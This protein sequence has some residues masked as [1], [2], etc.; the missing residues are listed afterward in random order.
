MKKKVSPVDIIVYT[1]FISIMIIS[2][3]DATTKCVG[4]KINL[5]IVI[6]AIITLLYL[7]FSSIKKY[8]YMVGILIF[9]LPRP[10][11]IVKKLISIVS[12]LPVF[13][14]S[15]I[16]NQGLIQEYSGYFLDA[17]VVLEVL[18]VL[19]FYF[20]IVIN[21]KTMLVIILGY[22]IITTYYFIGV[23]NLYKDSVWFLMSGL[24]LY[25][26]N[27][28]YARRKKLNNN[29]LEVSKRYS[30]K[31]ISSTIFITLIA[32]FIA[33]ILPHDK[34]PVTLDWIDGNVFSKFESFKSKE[35]LSSKSKFSIS[36]TGFQENPGRL[37]GAVKTDDSLVLVIKDLDTSRNVHLRGS[38]RDKYNG[39]IWEKSGIDN[40]KFEG[41]VASKGPDIAYNNKTIKITHKK[42]KVS[43]AFNVL[44]PDSIEN[45]WGYAYEDMDLE[46]VHPGVIKSGKS[47]NVKYRDYNITKDIIKRQYNKDYQFNYGIMGRYLSIPDTIPERVSELVYQ[48]T[49]DCK[50][51]YERVSAIENYLKENYPYSMQ[52]SNLPEGQDF[53][54]YFLFQEKKGYCTYFAS[55]MAVMTRMAGVPSRYVEGFLVTDKSDGSGEVE[56]LNSDAHAW[57][58]IYLGDLGWVTFDPT[59]GNE[60]NSIETGEGGEIDP[61]KPDN[62]ETPDNINYDHSKDNRKVIDKDD[63]FANTDE[64]NKNESITININWGQV[65]K[66]IGIS[67]AAIFI[68][69][70][71]VYAIRY[72]IIKTKNKF[73][74]YMISKM[75][76][77]GRL[78]GYPYEGG[79]TLRE[80][81]ERFGRNIKTDLNYLIE[82]FE[83]HMYNKKRISSKDYHSIKKQM[84]RLDS[85]VRKESGWFKFYYSDFK[86][87]YVFLIKYISIRKGHKKALF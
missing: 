45:K 37:G 31:L 77:Y 9:I 58:E 61:S 18:L 29:K 49:K 2:I 50:T 56:V 13:I 38:I 75:L 54:D 34:K 79:D 78:L 32:G 21:K 71:I 86:N 5:L 65:F 20:I 33:G 69:M 4:L 39:Y 27:N 80:Y 43:T 85:I 53:V 28:F 73:I 1:L 42:L 25:G 72:R 11:F 47:Y 87:M 70:M 63:D 74:Y 81:I 64:S 10:L 30:Y 62:T 76:L 40:R 22:S 35:K 14:D 66:C 23:E 19:V 83:L 55:A 51:P 7:F 52:T 12:E 6:V 16:Q 84:R 57:V 60:S 68:I 24:I 59:P 36:R 15:L 41:E 48:I 46:L 17:M 44:Y 82:I 3:I 67:F 8:I 26:Y